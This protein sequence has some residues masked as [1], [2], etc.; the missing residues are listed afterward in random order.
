MLEGF[1]V[2]ARLEWDV[3]ALNRRLQYQSLY[4]TDSYCSNRLSKEKASCGFWKTC[5]RLKRGWIKI[6]QV[7][8]CKCEFVI[9]LSSGYTDGRFVVSIVS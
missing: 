8:W 4:S 5:S 9:S 3:L 6:V 2:R 7:I 1:F